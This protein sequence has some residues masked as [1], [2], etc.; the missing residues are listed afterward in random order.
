MLPACT[1]SRVLEETSY[2][3]DSGR[4]LTWERDGVA[5]EDRCRRRN[6]WCQSTALSQTL[7]R[8]VVLLCS[9]AVRLCCC[10]GVVVCCCVAVRVGFK[11]GG[12]MQSGLG[13]WK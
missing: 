2:V 9:C 3:S 6:A 4:L 10:G 1:C 8:S 11:L 7:S 12:R 5:G 13:G